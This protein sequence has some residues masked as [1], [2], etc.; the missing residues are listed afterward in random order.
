MK[1]LLQRKQ[2]LISRFINELSPSFMDHATI[3]D[4]FSACMAQTDMLID[5]DP[6]SAL[7]H[8]DMADECLQGLKINGLITNEAF[9]QFSI[10]LNTVKNRANKAI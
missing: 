8:L 3:E 1:T 2:F 10:V 6:L 7:Y 5:V 4:D 9:D